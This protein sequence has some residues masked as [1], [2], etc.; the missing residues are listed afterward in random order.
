MQIDR[1][2]RLVDEIFHDAQQSA[3]GRIV[4]VTNIRIDHVL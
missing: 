2:R 1:R 3:R 4:C